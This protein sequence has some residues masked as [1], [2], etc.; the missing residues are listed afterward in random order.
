[1]SQWAEKSQK[2]RKKY[3]VHKVL[4]IRSPWKHPNV[5]HRFKTSTRIEQ[6]SEGEGESSVSMQV[7]AP[8]PL[9]NMRTVS[10]H[11]SFFSENINVVHE[12]EYSYNQNVGE[13]SIPYS[14]GDGANY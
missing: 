5:L 14:Q 10:F 1:M 9:P 11:S 8:S 2:E 6:S 12:V 4:G 3:E 7:A 13:D